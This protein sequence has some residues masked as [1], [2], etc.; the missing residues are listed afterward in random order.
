MSHFRCYVS[1]TLY[2][3]EER[4]SS[5]ETIWLLLLFLEL[6]TLSSPYLC[7]LKAQSF[8]GAKIYEYS[9]QCH[10]CKVRTPS[11]CVKNQFYSNYTNIPTSQTLISLFVLL[12]MSVV[13]LFYF[14]IFC[15]TLIK[16]LDPF[17][18]FI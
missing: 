6:P 5:S 1:P 11:Q 9:S 10:I 14:H 16:I 12:F 18:S 7:F 8:V 3:S 2:I 17:V 4:K 13:S 15:L